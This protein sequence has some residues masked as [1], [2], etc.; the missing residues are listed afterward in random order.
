MKPGAGLDIATVAA[1]LPS[2]RR[3]FAA[4]TTRVEEHLAAGDGY[5]S[6]SG[7]KDS[8]AVVHLAANIAPDIPVVF[9]DS[10]LEFPETYTYLEQLAER[11]QLNFHRIAATPDALTIMRR[12]GA[13]HDDPAD[14]PDRADIDMHH[15]LVTV[16]SRTAHQRFGLHNLW[17]LRA[18]ES[19]GRQALLRPRDGVFWRENTHRVCSPIWDWR[20][21]A[22][23]A[24]L[25]AHDVPLNPV[26]DKL[27]RLGATGPDL[28]V[29][30]A[31][32]GNNLNHGRVHWLRLGWPDLFDHLCDHLPRL[33][34]YR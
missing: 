15:A 5:V 2:T 25:V 11:W 10:G 8:T 34:A 20:E 33:R 12:S 18:E 30:L 19:Q 26:Y 31:L 27:T 14:V 4:A 24:Y 32:D 9:F 7:G 16:P 1:A 28:R 3:K 22:L 23:H 13:W 6:W 17:G 21:T 29:G